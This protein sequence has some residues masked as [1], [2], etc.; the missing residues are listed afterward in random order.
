MGRTA[1]GR[2]AAQLQESPG[3]SA[4]SRRESE[5]AISSEPSACHKEQKRKEKKIISMQ[6]LNTLLL[7]TYTP[8]G[9]TDALECF[10]MLFVFFFSSQEESM[11]WYQK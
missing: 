10:L 11:L 6:V 9:A 4:Y 8:M 5:A 3:S 2:E 1:H 7:N